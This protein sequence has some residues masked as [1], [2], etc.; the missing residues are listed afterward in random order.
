MSKLRL[1]PWANKHLCAWVDYTYPPDA[2]TT[3]ER[4]KTAIRRY[5]HRY[6]EALARMSWPEML[7]A[8]KREGLD[9]IEEPT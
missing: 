7:E 4:A 5:V 6:P 2:L 9:K 1:D 3:S 8:A